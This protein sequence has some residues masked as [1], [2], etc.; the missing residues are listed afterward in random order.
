[1]DYCTHVPQTSLWV[2]NLSGFF[3]SIGTIL[4][5]DKGRAT[6]LMNKE[7]YYSKVNQLI[8][9]GTYTLVQKDPTKNQETIISHELKNLEREDKIP[10]MLYNRLR[11]TGCRPPLLYGL[12]N[13]HKSGIPLRPIVYCIGSPSSNVS[14]F[15]SN[16]ISPLFGKTRSNIK[17]STHFMQTVSRVCLR[18]DKMMVS[19]DGSSLFTNVPIDEAYL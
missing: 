18:S 11:P 3:V 6:V 13:I 7:E 14:K 15:I 12:P 9:S 5:A 17:N 8:Q 19:F 1:M 10:T 4:P 16:M 2:G